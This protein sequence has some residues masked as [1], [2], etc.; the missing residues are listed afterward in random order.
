M[1]RCAEAYIVPFQNQARPVEGSLGEGPRGR[2]GHL[3]VHPR[4]DEE[5]AEHDHEDHGR[6]QG[7]HGRR[8]AQQGHVQHAAHGGLLLTAQTTFEPRV[9]D[10]CKE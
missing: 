10:V 9:L 6:S 8:H 2:H 7:G 4:R 1:A 3:D 5:G